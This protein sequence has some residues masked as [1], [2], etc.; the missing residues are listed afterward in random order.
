MV[1]I[2]TG[3]EQRE[4]VVKLLEQFIE[5]SLGESHKNL[6]DFVEKCMKEFLNE[7]LKKSWETSRKEF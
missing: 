6:E 4:A 7:S 2:G 5:E 1:S 3:L